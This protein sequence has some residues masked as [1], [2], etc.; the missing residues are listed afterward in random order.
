MLKVIAHKRLSGIVL[1]HI[2]K[3][4]NMPEKAYQVATEVLEMYML[5]DTEVLISR[6]DRPTPM[7]EI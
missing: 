6:Q 1:A 5:K 3:E 7:M 2:S 4:N